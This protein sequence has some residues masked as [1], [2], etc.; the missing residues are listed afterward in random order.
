MTQDNGFY[1]QIANHD[2]K[3]MTCN[4]MIDHYN[5]LLGLPWNT[6]QDIATL[7]YQ[8]NCYKCYDV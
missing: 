8:L 5:F 1:Q 2:V 7:Q 6:E 4:M 3:E